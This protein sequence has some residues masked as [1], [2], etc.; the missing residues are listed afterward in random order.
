MLLAILSLAILLIGLG[1]PPVTR[2]QEAR[3]LETARQMMHQPLQKWLIPELNDE[4]RL[5]KPPFAYWYT[6]IAFKAFGVSD[7]TGRLPTAILAGFTL[8]ATYLVGSLLFNPRVGLL[9]STM[10]MGCYLFAR[11]ARLAE[12][13]L[14]ATLF[15]TV[16]VLSIVRTLSDPN[17]SP[18]DLH[19]FALASG[20][21]IVSKGGPAV[22]AILFLIC[23]ACVER[24]FDL[25]TRFITSGA[26][27]TLLVVAV[28]WFAYVAHEHGLQ[29]FLHELRNTAEG[30]DHAG[31]ILEYVA[32]IGWGGAPWSFVLPFAIYEAI[33]RWKRDW[34]LRACLMWIACIALPLMFNGNRQ[35]HY[36][37]PMFPAIVVLVAWWI[38]ATL[39]QL[40]RATIIAGVLAVILPVAVAVV[41]PALM[42][43]SSRAIAAR[44]NE[45][46]A[47]SDLRFFGDNRSPA[48][49]YNMRKQIPWVASNDDAL[50]LKDVTLLV[51]GKANRP[52]V[53]PPEL[54][55]EL[56]RFDAGGQSYAIYRRP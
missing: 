51:I 25:P 48:I 30:G 34:R 28:P 6:A 24:R 38:D 26:I 37:L 16:A 47:A 32:V 42:E 13:D 53:R 23:I 12:T 36:L 33:M 39:K 3:V 54:Y 21:A 8:I 27:L 18:P 17:R 9:S 11:H 45:R 7:F 4:A 49:S 20:L 50:R 55:V 41:I 31:S 1:N 40:D 46:Y 10:L 35:K 19:L 44:L 56:E 2:T 14:P 43:D 5:Q 15:I 22:F 29:T 52:M